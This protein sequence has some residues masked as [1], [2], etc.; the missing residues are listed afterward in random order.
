MPNLIAQ[1]YQKII[2]DYKPGYLYG[3]VN[4][5]KLNTNAT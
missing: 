5:H 1:N 2:R 3:T 4:I